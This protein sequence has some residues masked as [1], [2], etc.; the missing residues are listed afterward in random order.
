MEQQINLHSM[1]TADNKTQF[2]DGIIT[3]VIDD[4]EYLDGKHHI[5]NPKTAAAYFCCCGEQFAINN[6]ENIAN[7]EDW[8]MTELLPKFQMLSLLRSPM[9]L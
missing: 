5:N 4:C 9:L 3:I 8:Y 1:K 2:T 7:V 6:D